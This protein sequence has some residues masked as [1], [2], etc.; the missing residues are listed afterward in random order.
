MS[1]EID[2][3]QATMLLEMY[4]GEACS[5]MLIE[6]DKSYHSGEGLYVFSTDYPE[7]GFVFLGKTNEEAIP[8]KAKRKI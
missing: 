4:G 8:Q 1:I 2:F 6:G 3:K 7:E 5:L